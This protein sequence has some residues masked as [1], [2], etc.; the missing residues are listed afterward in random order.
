MYIPQLFVRQEGGNRIEYLQLWIGYYAPFANI[1]RDMW[2]WLKQEGYDIYRNLLQV[3]QSQEVG[4][5]TY[6]HQTMDLEALKEVIEEKA[7]IEVELKYKT[8]YQG[9]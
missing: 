5:F 8:I 7:G 2:R 4:F 9:K 3:E 6:S 1:K